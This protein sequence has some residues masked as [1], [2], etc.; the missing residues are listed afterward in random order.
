MFEAL[1]LGI[2]EGL[3]EFLPV[4][5]TGHLLILQHWLERRS[6]LFN[7]AI[8]AGAI[9]AVTWVYRQ[10]IAELG[11]AWREPESRDYLLKLWSAFC[12]TGVLGFAAKLAGAELPETVMPVAAALIIGG[13]VIFVA[14][15]YARHHVPAQRVTWTVVL[16]VGVAQV[17]AGVFPGTSRSAAAIFA[18]MFAGLTVRRDAAEFAF[19][20]G[21]PTMF[22]ASGYEL[23]KTLGDGA[24]TVAEDWGELAVAFVAATATGFLAV[25]WLLG[26]ISGHTFIVFA[27][28]RIVLGFV[29]LLVLGT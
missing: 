8:Q 9:V 3:T 1:V 18:A 20:V 11:R 17:V 6:S 29:L 22:A 2:V 19:L 27:W 15:Y 26:F 28:Y 5:S 23:A 7:I 10:R 14:E 24:A 16:A 25:K 13:F 21:I 4:S 12:V